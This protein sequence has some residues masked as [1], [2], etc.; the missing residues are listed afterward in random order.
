MNKLKKFAS[1]RGNSNMYTG[2]RGL[3]NQG[4]TCYLNTVLQTFFMTPEFRDAVHEYSGPEK[5]EEKNLL[6]QLKKLFQNLEDG[7]Y[8]VKTTGVTRSLGM[9]HRDVWVQQDVAEFFRKILNEVSKESPVSENYQSTVINSIKCLRCGTEASDNSRYLD[10]PLPLNT[11][12]HSASI[13]YSVE[14]GLLDFLKT[15]LLEGDN[16][17]YCDKCEMK[18]DTETRYYF[19][20]L[21]QILTLHLKRFEFDYYQMSYVKI[22]CPVEIPLE[23]QFQV[24]PTENTEWCFS[25]TIPQLPL[26]MKMRSRQKLNKPK[27]TMQEI[28]VAASKSQDSV[29]YELFA[30]CDHSGVYKGG[31]YTA[32]IKSFENGKWYTFDDSVVHK[33]SY[34]MEQDFTQSVKEG[35]RPCISS[36]TAYLLMYRK[37]E[38]SK[39]DPRSTETVTGNQRDPRST[40]TV[41]GNQ[42]DPR[43]TETVI[44]NQ[45]DPRS[46]ETVNGNQRDPRSTETVI[47]NQK[48]PSSKE[49]VNGNQRDPRST[50][51]NRN[52]RDPRGT[53][54]VNC[55]PHQLDPSGLC[56]QERPSRSQRQGS[57]DAYTGH[58]G[59]VVASGRG[60]Q[61]TGQRGAAALHRPSEDRPAASGD[62]R[63]AAQRPTTPA[64][65][66]NETSK[67]DNKNIVNGNQRDPRSTETNRNQ[68]DP[69]S[70]ETNRNQRDPRSTESPKEGIPDEV[71]K[72]DVPAIL[73]KKKDGSWCLCLDYKINPVTKDSYL[74]N[75]INEALDYIVGSCWFSSLD[76]RS[77]DSE[78]QLSLE[79][80][81]KTVDRERWQ[82]Q[83][84]LFGL[85]MFE[86]LVE[87]VLVT[88]TRTG[89]FIYLDDLEVH[90][91]SF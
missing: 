39:P 91:P 29:R 68:R 54:T 3:I 48:D 71:Q 52:Q 53:K 25:A 28:A 13:M 63:S 20:R 89:Y 9:M 64:L 38:T 27:E 78:V 84:K 85:Y 23:L 12:D 26:K 46:T 82:F 11:T 67:P 65:L 90:T 66:M 69:R 34:L 5:D 72:W 74:Q 47:G 56:Y 15:E 75:R 8:E 87:R 70:T 44:G 30:I 32:R 50:E 35:K 77:G 10:I 76:L 49:T 31:H 14:K 37:S 18:T 83:V 16:Q 60:S 40:E 22:Q 24:A 36:S 42:R 88:V 19:Q 7:E 51:T 2:Y 55:E 17:S 41:I 1:I 73:G 43:S 45:R 58:R 86:C 80:R 61:S 4:A 62:E 21:P 57:D 33:A 81:L 59:A 6:F 79:V